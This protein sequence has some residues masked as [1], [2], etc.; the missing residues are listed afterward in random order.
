VPKILPVL[1][2]EHRTTWLRLIFLFALLVVAKIMI[3]GALSVQKTKY[4]I[5]TGIA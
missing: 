1:D 3:W 2:T 4:N 5:I